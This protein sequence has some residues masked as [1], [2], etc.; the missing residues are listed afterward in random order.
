[1]NNS[2]AVTKMLQ[3]F[4]LIFT[5]H[6]SGDSV[7]AAAELWKGLLGDIPEAALLAAQDQILK[8]FTHFPTPADV[9]SRA[10]AYLGDQILRG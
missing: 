10:L 3:K 8:E 4:M 2:S 9:R 5:W 1:M 6:V 7:L